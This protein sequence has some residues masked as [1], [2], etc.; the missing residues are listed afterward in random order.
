[1][2]VQQGNTKIMSETLHRSNSAVCEADGIIHGY[3]QDIGYR[4]RAAQP[5][6]SGM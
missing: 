2:R 3:K 6:Y 5:T 1:M 4:V